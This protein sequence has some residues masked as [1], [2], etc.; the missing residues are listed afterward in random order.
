MELCPLAW[1]SRGH[2]EIRI[3]VITLMRPSQGWTLTFSHGK[4][5][6]LTTG[7][8]HPGTEVHESPFPGVDDGALSLHQYCGHA[9][10]SNPN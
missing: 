10:V 6:G 2:I 9:P 3:A 7:M 8:K 5:E 4:A 1:H